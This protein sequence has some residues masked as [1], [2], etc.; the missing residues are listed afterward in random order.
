MS[1]NLM[2]LKNVKR[3][4]G[5]VTAQ[6]PACADEGGDKKGDHLFINAD[7]KFGCVVN[8]GEGG[9]E[10]RQQIFALAGDDGPGTIVVRPV[11]RNPAPVVLVEG[12]MKQLKAMWSEKGVTPARCGVVGQPAAQCA[13]QI[14]NST[15]VQPI[16]AQAVAGVGKP[17]DDS[18]VFSDH[19][20]GDEVF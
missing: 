19:P 20:E 16:G 3:H 12:I 2:K 5:K 14:A 4:N 8:P 1:L 11:E 7:G 9:K 10:H 13:P 6:C 15:P 18:N 17:V